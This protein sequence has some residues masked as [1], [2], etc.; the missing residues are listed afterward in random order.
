MLDEN[1]PDLITLED[2]SGQEFT[3]EIVDEVDCD[4]EHYVAL[5]PYVQTDEEAAA[6]LEEEASLII[7]RVSEEDGENVFDTVDDDEELYRVGGVFAKR[8]DELYDLD[9]EE[10]PRS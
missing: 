7:M 2:E 5:V 4:G 8:L 10:L 1:A 9:D 3:F 6:A